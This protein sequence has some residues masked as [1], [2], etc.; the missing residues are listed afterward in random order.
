[1]NEGWELCEMEGISKE[2][3]ELSWDD[4]FLNFL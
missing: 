3:F 2:E 4:S 1:M